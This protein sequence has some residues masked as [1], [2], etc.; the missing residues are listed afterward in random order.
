MIEKNKCKNTWLIMLLVFFSA[1]SVAFGQQS[2]EN[3][4][5]NLV[6]ASDSIPPAS[7]RNLTN[8][9]YDSSY[10]IWTWTEP[11]DADFTKVMVYVNGIFKTN[12][13][14]GK[15]I[16][17]AKNLTNNTLYNISTH[18]VDTS[19]NINTTW[20]YKLTRTSKYNTP[21]PRISNLKNLSGCNFIKWTWT[22]PKN[23]DFSKV[24]VYID[25]KFKKN[26]SK[27]V[28]YYN[29]VGL[30]QNTTHRISTRTVDSYGSIGKWLNDTTKTARC[31]VLIVNDDNDYKSED[32][33]SVPKFQ[34]V[35]RNIGYNVTI[36]KS[37]ETLNST[38]GKYN[39]LVWS[40]GD[41][42]SAINNTK[43]EEMLVDHSVRGRR[44]IVESGNAARWL[45]VKEEPQLIDN[46]LRN[47]VLHIT[48]NYT[49]S[50]TG[51]LTFANNH[52]IA[53]TPNILPK[54]IGFT[55]TDPEDD[56]SG[57]ADAVRILPNAVGIYN[58]S[59]VK[60]GGNPINPGV[61]RKSY[62]LIAYDNDANVSNGGQIV[63]FAFDIDDID[64]PEIQRKLIEN[65]EKWLKK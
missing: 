26:I 48:S 27:G 36:E 13:T 25:G 5:G 17:I 19:G 6:Y 59:Y 10:I 4:E 22:D 28:Q 24:M 61:A 45:Q 8:T 47:Y 53:T 3:T 35:F 29:A 41:D 60:Y 43:Y 42:V 11:K 20:I 39:L 15:K 57:D 50:D 12:V 63:Y 64:S 65:S 55:P 30:I 16:Y 1:A 7:V 34:S 40:D 56:G 33:Q 9:S 44:L 18:T 37:S 31:T 52:P 49:Y 2:N 14:K 54:T 38:W 51:N 62:G 46:E 23:P 21:P 58:W 32:D